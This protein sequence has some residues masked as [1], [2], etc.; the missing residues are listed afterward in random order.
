M[1]FPVSCILSDTV[2]TKFFFMMH[3]AAELSFLCVVN[4][5]I[6]QNLYWLLKYKLIVILLEKALT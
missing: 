5:F 2:H 6:S 3:Q 4:T 1:M